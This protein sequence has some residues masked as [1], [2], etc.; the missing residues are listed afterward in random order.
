MEFDCLETFSGG[1]A[2]RLSISNKMIKVRNPN[3]LPDQ[4]KPFLKP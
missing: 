3:N 1:V 4:V 2:I